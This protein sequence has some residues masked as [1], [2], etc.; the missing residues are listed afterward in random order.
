MCERLRVGCVC[1]YMCACMDVCVMRG[2]W[3]L[4][5]S[6]GITNFRILPGLHQQSFC[7]VQSAED[8][9]GAERIKAGENSLLYFLFEGSG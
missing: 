5:L 7:G 4:P 1:V 3:L 8:A 2:M 9:H 6:M